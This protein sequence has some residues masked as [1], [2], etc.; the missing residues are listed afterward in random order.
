MTKYFH[1]VEDILG[2]RSIYCLTST[3]LFSK[4]FFF[5]VVK[6]RDYVVKAI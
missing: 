6:S 3:S 1:K 4:P 5:R 2:K